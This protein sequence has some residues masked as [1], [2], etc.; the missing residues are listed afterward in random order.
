MMSGRRG[1]EREGGSVGVEG[2][3][4]GGNTPALL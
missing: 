1:E 4:G 2:R 3:R